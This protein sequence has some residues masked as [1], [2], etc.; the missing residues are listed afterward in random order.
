MTR[1]ARHVVVAPTLALAAA[2]FLIGCSSWPLF[3]SAG[4]ALGCVIER[5]G[6]L[7]EG[8][9]W[10]SSWSSRTVRVFGI[11]GADEQDQFI[12]TVRHEVRR[13]GIP[14][15]FEFVVVEFWKGDPPPRGSNPNRETRNAS[16][17]VIRSVEV[18]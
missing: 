17:D 12:E 5:E 15:G 6:L 11:D 2:S 13:R 10:R 7:P 1:P 14:R 9:T 16:F 4:D 3:V 18:R 8:A